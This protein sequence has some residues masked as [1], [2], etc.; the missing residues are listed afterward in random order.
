MTASKKPAAPKPTL[1]SDHARYKNF[2]GATV[3]YH[4]SA[5]AP[6][7]AREFFG[8]VRNTIGAV[9]DEEWLFRWEVEHFGD[10]LYPSAHGVLWF[11][12]TNMGSGAHGAGAAAAQARVAWDQGSLPLPEAPQ[13]VERWWDK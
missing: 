8:W 13:N 3:L 7:L 10:R 12:I 4:V 9:A 6:E 11:Q 2:Q 1:T 5:N